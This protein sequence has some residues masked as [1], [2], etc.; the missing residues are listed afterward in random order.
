M[1]LQDFPI[2]QSNVYENTEK[3]LQQGKEK[4]PEKEKN[5]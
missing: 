1:V 5:G 3:Y 2:L 4:T